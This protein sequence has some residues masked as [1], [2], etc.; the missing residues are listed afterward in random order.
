VG[1]TRNHLLAK[2]STAS[3]DRDAAVQDTGAESSVAEGS[4]SPS[5]LIFQVRENELNGI[6]RQ[7]NESDT[8]HPAIFPV[9]AEKPATETV[10]R[11]LLKTIAIT[12][13]KGICAVVIVVGSLACIN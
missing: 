8:A 6:E 3:P 5:S 13:F 2:D 10:Q 9:F 1:E 11:G 4:L 7:K 12:V